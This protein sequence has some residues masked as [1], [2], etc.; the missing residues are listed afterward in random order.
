MAAPAAN[1]S[2]PSMNL[3]P[4][5]PALQIKLL[6]DKAQAPTRGS[7]FAAGY[8]LYSAQDT[9]IPARGKAI[10]DTDISLAV[11]AGTCTLSCPLEPLIQSAKS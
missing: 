9:T 11:P 1:V 7:E 6:S 4:A 8:D 3:E 2:L 10:V 5:P